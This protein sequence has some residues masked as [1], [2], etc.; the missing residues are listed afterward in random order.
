MKKNEKNKP[1]AIEEHPIAH[2][3]NNQN[4]HQPLEQ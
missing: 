1:D 2:T 4:R 3:T